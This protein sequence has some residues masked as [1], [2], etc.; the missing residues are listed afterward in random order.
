[1]LS[2]TFSRHGVIVKYIAI[3]TKPTQNR[4]KEW[5]K[6]KIKIKFGPLN[7]LKPS[8]ALHVNATIV[9]LTTGYYFRCK[10]ST[11]IFNSM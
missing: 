1:M 9:P 10:L 5:L 6:H 8:K 3:C 4:I 2:T 7:V 11:K